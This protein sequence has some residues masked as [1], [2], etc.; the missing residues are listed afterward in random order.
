MKLY[1]QYLSGHIANK[2]Y[3]WEVFDN[4]YK[5]F[6]IYP[7]TFIPMQNSIFYNFIIFDGKLH[8]TAEYEQERSHVLKFNGKCDRNHKRTWL[9]KPPE[10]WLKNT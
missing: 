10:L 1:H 4:T 9:D 8:D 6:W 2:I 7:S 5:I 3:P